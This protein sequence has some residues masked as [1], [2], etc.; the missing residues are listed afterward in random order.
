LSGEFVTNTSLRREA[1]EEKNK[2]II[3]NLRYADCLQKLDLSDENV[4]A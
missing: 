2:S 3:Q 4:R 1:E